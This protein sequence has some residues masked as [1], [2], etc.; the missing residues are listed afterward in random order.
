MD[1][2]QVVVATDTLATYPGGR[3][4][5]FVTKAFIV[6]HLKLIMAGVGTSGFLA[7]WFVFMNDSVIVRGIDNLDYHTP[8]ALRMLWQQHKQELSI[9]DRLTTTVYHLGFSEET[10]LIHA[11]AYRSTSDFKSEKLDSYGLRLKPECQVPTDYSLPQDFITIMDKQRTVQ[12]SKPEEERIHIGGE[13]EVH[14]L[15]KGGFQAFTLH[16]F[17]DYD[18]DEKAIFDGCQSLDNQCPQ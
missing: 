17:A 6:P 10:G 2:T 16:R 7:R 3:P 13:I 9:P 15:S 12:A 14:Y 11:Y 4:F 8:R 1:E 5:K 18:R